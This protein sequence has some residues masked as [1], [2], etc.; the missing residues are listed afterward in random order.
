VVLL[1]A[2]RRRGVAVVLIG[3]AG[4]ILLVAAIWWFLT[5]RGAPR[6]AALVLG[7]SVPPA[8][9]GFYVANGVTL[10]AVGSLALATASAWAG[11]AALRYE[12]GRQWRE[13]M[14]ASSAG[15]R[16]VGPPRDPV[17]IMNPRSGDGKVARFDL[18]ARAQALGARVV[19]LSGSRHV[20]VAELARGAI[21]DGADLLAVAGGDGT[22]ALVAAVAA[23]HDLP[24]LV[25]PAGTRNHFALDLG[26][27]RANPAAGLDA[28]SDGLEIRVDLGTAGGHPFVNNASFGA[29]AEV[30]QSPDYRADKVRT[31]LDMLPDLLVRSGGPRLRAAVDE[32][33]VA[34][35]AGAAT[36]D[37]FTVGVI[38]D[39]QA[40]LVS[41][42][43]YGVGDLGGLGRRVRLDEGVLGV[44]SLTARN[45]VEAAALLRREHAR[46]LVVGAYREVVVTSD[47]PRIPVAIDGEAQVLPTPVRCAIRPLALRVRVPRD[48]PGL[49]LPRPPMSWRRLRVMALRGRRE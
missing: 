24:F 29:Y 5:R 10:I 38:D 2:A 20:D 6:V 39:P 28:L 15:A 14:A 8:V 45:T 4:V 18:V 31:T 22:Q 9:L 32:A 42:N 7:L 13:E 25:I 27:D 3:F 46:G 30:V 34:G 44:V 33:A 49:A 35:T 43:R 47:E 40:V 36:R 11:R 1:D 37:E 19:L 41:N 21:A 48:R 23:D 16:P 17:L 26:L 12:A